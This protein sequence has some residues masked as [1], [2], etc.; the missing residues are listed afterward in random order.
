V[1]RAPRDLPTERTAIEAAAGRLLSGAPLR[2]TEGKLSTTELI[3]ESGL[4]R[5]KV[6]EHRD[7]VQ[8]FQAR[9]N[10]TDAVPDPTLDLAATNQRL[11]AQLAE[12]TAALNDERARSA[13]L[14]RA[15]TEASIELH[16][17][18]QD[19]AANVTEFRPPAIRRARHCS[20][21]EPAPR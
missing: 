15:L 3:T 11:A 5:W 9:V 6:Y 18:R 1:S 19:Q 17:A 2:A 10:A 21:R 4:P 12:T 16:Q 20:T 14:R 7:L 13:L 8:D